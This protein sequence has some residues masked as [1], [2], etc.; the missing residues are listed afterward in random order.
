LRKIGEAVGARGQVAF[1]AA[2]YPVAALLVHCSETSHVEACAKC[3]AFPGQYYRPEAFFVGKP[4]GSGNQRV[5]HRGIERIHLVRP[6]QPDVGD[7][8]RNRHR[9][10]VIHAK[11]PCCSS[12]LPLYRMAPSGFSQSTN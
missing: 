12:L 5:E 8:L 9:H 7:T 3:T 10:P 11:S 4:A 6:N 2:G 1:L